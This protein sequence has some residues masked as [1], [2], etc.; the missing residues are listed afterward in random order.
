MTEIIKR[1]PVLSCVGGASTLALQH[2]LCP[3]HGT[4]A[5]SAKVLA[6]VG[7]VSTTSLE[8]LAK[9]TEHAVTGRLE[10]M[11]LSAPLAHD[12]YHASVDYALPIVGWSLLAHSAYHL[13]KKY[14]AK[15]THKGCIH[16]PP[17]G[18]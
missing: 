18:A 12:T 17:S 14:L 16:E 13:G 15:R 10:Y 1:A 7:A 3:G 6:G 11:G 4:I 2:L 9:G 8:E 5:F